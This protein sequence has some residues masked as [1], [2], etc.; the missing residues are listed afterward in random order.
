M[1]RNLCRSLV[2]LERE[3]DFE[4]EGAALALRRYYSSVNSDMN[5]GLGKG[6]RHGFS[7]DLVSWISM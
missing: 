6:W 7:V 3:T 5:V 4:I 2:G 1:E